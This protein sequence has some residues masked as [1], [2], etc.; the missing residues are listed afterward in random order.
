[1]RDLVQQLKDFQPKS[2]F[3]IGIDSDGCAFDS[4]ELKH[5]ECFCPNFIKHFGLQ[6][7]SKYARETWDFVN[8]YS[9]T[10]GYNRFRAVIV[11]LDLLRERPEVRERKVDIP[12][13][14]GLREWV[15]RESKL[16][17]PALEAELQ[18]NPD[19]DLQ[20]AY[21]WSKG[22]NQSVEEIVFNL[23]PFPHLPLGLQK[24]QGQADVLVVSQT[25]LEAL[26]REWE[27]HGIDKYTRLIA[28]QEMGTKTEHI[29][30]GADGKYPADH[31]LM[32]G[33]APGDLRAAQANQALFYPIIPGQEEFSWQRFFEEGLDRFLNGS[34]KGTYGEQL[35]VEFDSSLPEKPAWNS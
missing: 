1:M 8:L 25:P 21:R 28:G 15:E 13:M 10:R 24:L 34:Y 23:P 29:A 31:I 5:K 27:E 22:V 11:A 12:E 32:I 7:V 19:P 14:Q 6:A 20:L 16:G 18:R 33:D 26:K 17:N 9:K 4:M 30:L 35:A 3:F 2:G